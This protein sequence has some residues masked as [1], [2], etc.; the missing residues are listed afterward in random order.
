MS[1]LRTFDQME[2]QPLKERLKCAQ[3]LL[4]VVRNGLKRTK[5]ENG[6]LKLLVKALQEECRKLYQKIEILEA[7]NAE[8]VVDNHEL[9][10]KGF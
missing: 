3:E 1:N 8:L 10:S 9:T 4:V 6:E 2:D 5:R 7:K